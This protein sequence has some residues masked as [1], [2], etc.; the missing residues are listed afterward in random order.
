MYAH[1]SLKKP[2]TFTMYQHARPELGATQQIIAVKE[3]NP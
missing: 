1:G 2:E 3:G